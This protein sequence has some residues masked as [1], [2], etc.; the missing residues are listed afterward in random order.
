MTHTKIIRLTGRPPVRIRCHDWP[1]IAEVSGDSSAGQDTEALHGQACGRNQVD[2]YHL[3]VH[4]HEDGRTIVYATLTAASRACYSPARGESSYAGRL[5]HSDDSI[6]ID[7]D[8]VGAIYDVARDSG[9]PTIL[10][11]RCIGRLPAVDL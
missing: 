4:R 11:R 3:G 2:F 5:I 9:I 6:D 1:M 8:T 7:A 10:A